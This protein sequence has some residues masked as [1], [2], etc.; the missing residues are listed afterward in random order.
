MSETAGREGGFFGSYCTLWSN[1]EW[2]LFSSDF[3]W[4]L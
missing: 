4:F 2:W 3:Y 1:N